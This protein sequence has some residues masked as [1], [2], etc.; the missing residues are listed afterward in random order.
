MG[1]CIELLHDK[2]KLD[3]DVNVPAPAVTG[4]TQ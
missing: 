4:P 3:E 2:P 1:A